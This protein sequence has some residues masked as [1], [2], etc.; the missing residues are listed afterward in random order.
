MNDSTSSRQWIAIHRPPEDHHLSPFVRKAIQPGPPL[1]R[2]HAALPTQSQS[3]ALSVAKKAIPAETAVQ[4]EHTFAKAPRATGYRPLATSKSASNGT[5]TLPPVIDVPE[6]TH[7][8]SAAAPP[9]P[10]DIALHDILT[11][12]TPLPWT[13]WQ[14]ALQQHNLLLSFPNVPTGLRYGFRTGVSSAIANTF[15][16]PNHASA[17]QHSQFV[18]EH[19]ANELRLHRYSGP[20]SPQELLRLIGPFKTAPLG[21]VPKPN[22]SKFRLIQ[23]LSFPRNDP[24]I[25]SVN[26]EISPDDFPCE[27][28]TF[29][30]C[31]YFVSRCPIGTE[32]A[33]FDVEN[34]Y[35]IIPIHPNDQP[36]FC[37]SWEEQIYV[38]HCAPFG[39]ASACGLFGH[40]A[41]AF[42]AICLSRGVDLILKWV[43]D[44]IVARY[45]T[46][47]GP[48]FC[49][50]FDASLLFN[51]ATELGWP[52]SIPKHH[53]FSSTFKY[54]GFLW[55]LKARSVQIPEDKKLKYLE[56]LSHWPPGSKH[57]LK[58]AQQLSGTLNHCCL[59]V[60]HG[61]SRL[62]HLNR[63]I[64]SFAHSNNLFASRTINF[65]LHNE[66]TWWSSEL[67]HYFVGRQVACPP[68]PLSTSIFV[69]AS[70]SFGIGI[71][72]D[73]KWAAWKFTPSALANGRDIGWGE[74]VAIELAVTALSLLFPSHSHFLVVSDNQGVIGA[75]NSGHSKGIHQNASLSRFFATLFSHSSFLSATYI[76]SSNNPADP[77]SRGNLPP[78]SSRLNIHIPLDSSLDSLL[79]RL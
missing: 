18:T 30:Q 32:V 28:G 76:T 55:N 13:A 3:F 53:D 70:T 6:S 21:V 56:R 26:S 38:D 15:I 66:L 67:S 11:I 27:W 65:S 43:D 33:V 16:P 10:H 25:T 61:R 57:T 73:N 42:V 49:Y 71:L 78:L 34:A 48:H 31:Y 24:H 5:T 74:M 62:L 44:L 59:V 40:V 64:A 51:V 50:A 12:T 2:R 4:L 39:S 1:L 22:S 41:D 77:I 17:T 79:L 35:Q 20:Y 46:N 58:D 63:F 19:I 54:L 69:D 8:Q 37:I 7:A 36:H 52:W 9:M 72:I 68:P 60:P 14:N 47:D 45:P 75:I 23:D 29:P